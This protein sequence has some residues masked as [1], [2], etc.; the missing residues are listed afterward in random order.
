M[1]YRDTA[2][3]AGQISR[4]YNV[5]GYN[6]SH[7][8]IGKFYHNKLIVY[9]ILY[10]KKNENTTKSALINESVEAFYQPQNDIVTGGAILMVKNVNRQNLFTFNDLIRNLQKRRLKFDKK[11]TSENDDNFYCSELVYYILHNFKKDI[12]IKPVTKQLQG[13]DRLLLGRDTITYYPTDVFFN[14]YNFKV[15]KEWK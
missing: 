4:S 3:K 1:F 6:Y 15:I 11:F 9:H 14:N 10:D 5:N 12:I 13:I 7:V 2:S 8:A